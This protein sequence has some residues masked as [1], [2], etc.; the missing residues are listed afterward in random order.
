M[1]FSWGEQQIASIAK[2][3]A[4]FAPYFS[5]N[6]RLFLCV[7][8]QTQKNSKEEPCAW[9]NIEGKLRKSGFIL[10][11]S[12]NLGSVKSEE[13]KIKLWLWKGH[14]KEE[15]GESGSDESTTCTFKLLMISSWF[16]PLQ[17][18]LSSL[19]KLRWCILLS[20]KEFELTNICYSVG[21]FRHGIFI[22]LLPTKTAEKAMLNS[23]RQL[24]Q[25]MHWHFPVESF[26]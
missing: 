24:M 1:S 25:L 26:C 6:I 10:P 3:R 21:R 18:L 11:E 14:R 5:E 20:R 12:C 4:L 7:Q 19:W 2:G 8:N 22:L 17:I 13:E 23:V 16:P 15:G 9:Q